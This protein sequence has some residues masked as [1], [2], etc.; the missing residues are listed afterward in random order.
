MGGFASA[1]LQPAR[2]RSVRRQRW[3][4]ASLALGW[5]GLACAE[6]QALLTVDEA[7]ALSEKTGRPIFAV[8][9]A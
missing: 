7:V 8:A 6:A 3:M 5:I 9:G 2:S 4:A 1:F